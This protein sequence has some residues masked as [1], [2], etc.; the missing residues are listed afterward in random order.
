MFTPSPPLFRPEAVRSLSSPDNLDAL[1]KV[2]RPS[3]WLVVGA[4]GLLSV[5]LLMWSWMGALPVRVTLPGLLVS[6]QPMIVVTAQQAGQ[7]QSVQAKTGFEVQAGEPVMQLQTINDTQ[8]KS[9]SVLLAP[10]AGKWLNV[11]VTIGQSVG[12]GTAVAW[13][14]P[15]A[16]AEI[17]PQQQTALLVLAPLSLAQELKPELPAQVR[18]V[19]GTSTSMN[20]AMLWQAR[21][22]RVVG[23]PVP[24]HQISVHTGH[25]ALG[26]M[27]NSDPAVRPIWLRWDVPTDQKLRPPSNSGQVCEISIT[28][29]AERPIAKLLPFLARR[30]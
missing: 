28:L 29:S 4:V 18:C 12:A 19:Q 14:E 15:Q 24:Q 22:E 25:E 20:G 3:G 11:G 17:P 10:V 7:V 1:L 5:L 23:Y 8:A 21:I 6:T 30:T 26:Q 13:L 2:T 9:N 27:L 16:P